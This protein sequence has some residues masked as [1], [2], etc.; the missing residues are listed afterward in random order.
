MLKY[1]ASR[2][3]RDVETQASRIILETAQDVLSISQQLVPVDTGALR[4]SGRVEQVNPNRV[5]IIYGNETVE[6]ARIVEYGGGNSPAQPYLTPAMAEAESI[7]RQK[8][9]GVRKRG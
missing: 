8:A 3:L 2:I 1:D 9:A 4:Q 6:Y 7:I 5:R